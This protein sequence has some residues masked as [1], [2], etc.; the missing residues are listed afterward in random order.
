MIRKPDSIA[1]LAEFWDTH[2]GT[3]VPSSAIAL[4]FS[5]EERRAVKKIAEAR[6]REEVALLR[7]WVREKLHQT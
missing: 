6:G 4:P 2:D 3:I 1:E 7:E 5:D